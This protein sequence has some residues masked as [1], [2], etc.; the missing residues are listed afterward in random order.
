M[1]PSGNQFGQL[2]VHPA[3]EPAIG[4]P[5]HQELRF[6]RAL[7]AAP[8]G[9]VK[10]LATDLREKLGA[11]G[12]NIMQNNGKAAGQEIPHFHV[13]IIPRKIN[14]KRFTLRPGKKA[15]GDELDKALQKL[16]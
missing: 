8:A 1:A 13:H 3:T 11:D 5:L 10:K 2:L 7:T 12:I 9:V 4:R 6:L 14:D 16:K 15:E